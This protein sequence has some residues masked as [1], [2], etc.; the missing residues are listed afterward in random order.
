MGRQRGSARL[1]TILGL[2]AVLG[3]VAGGAFLLGRTTARPR[4]PEPLSPPAAQPAPT[5]VDPAPS[6]ATGAPDVPHAPDKGAPGLR[7]LGDKRLDS[8]VR[9]V[10]ASMDEKGRPPEGVGQGGRRGGARGLFDNA[11][12]RLPPQPRGYYREADV[13]PRGAAGRGSERLVFGKEGEVYYTADHYRTFTRI[14]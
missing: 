13:W 2:G 11:E 9:T 1:L 4:G 6:P 7:S 14:R 5:A 10:V 8:Q 12:G 3:I